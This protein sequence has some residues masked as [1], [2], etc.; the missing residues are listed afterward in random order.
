ME[1]PFVLCD[2]D[3][4]PEPQQSRQEP[5]QVHDDDAELIFVGVEHVNKDAE[6]IFV[7]M[8]SSSKPVNSNILNRVTP[9]SRL[10]RK[11][12]ELRKTTTQRSQPSGTATPTSETVIVL[13]ASPAESRATD[14]PIIIEPLS[15]PESS[16][17]QVVPNSSSECCSPSTALSRSKRSPR[18]VALSGGELSE[19]LDVSKCRSV[20]EVKVVNPQRPEPCV[21]VVEECSSALS[22][23]GTSHRTSNPQ[24]R[25]PSFGVPNSLNLFVNGA[26]LSEYPVHVSSTNAHPAHPHRKNGLAETDS[27]SLASQETF[28]PKKGSL[29]L[30]LSDFYYGQYKGDAQPDQ[31]K[32]HTAFKCPSCLKALK[33]IKFMNHAKHHLE[34]E[35]QGSDGWEGHTTCQHCHRQF[36]SPFQL[37]CHVDRVHTAPDPSVVCKICEL[38]FETDQ[39][40]LQHMKD[41]HKPGEMPYVCQVCKYRSS[42]FADVEIHFRKCHVNTKNLLCLFC[43]KVFKTGMPYMCHYRG[44]W[45]RSGHQCSKC[46][47]QFLTFKEKMEHKTQCHQMF[48]KP[49]QLEGLPPETKVVIQVSLEPVQS[50]SVKAAAVVVSTAD[51]EP[52]SPGSLGRP[53]NKSPQS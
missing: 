24:Q 48:Q 28:D 52:A 46:R 50:E 14:S 11:R 27:S 12:D 35:K 51:W 2:E 31:K 23:S 49:K 42:V 40:L 37:E 39:V 33:N 3:D 13:P 15:G 30:L 5:S 9:G 41:N 20:P 53:S 45:E 1:Q 32:T 6:L 8:T 17:P 43:L 36:P 22:P 10:K 25:G 18:R 29:T 7:G 34:I 16:S 47:L 26:S 19:R 38:S 44:H 4:D 21:E